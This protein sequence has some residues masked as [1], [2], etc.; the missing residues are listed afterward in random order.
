MR[1][2]TEVDEKTLFRKL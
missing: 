1:L 2:Y